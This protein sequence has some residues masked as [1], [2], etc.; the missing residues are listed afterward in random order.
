MSIIGEKDCIQKPDGTLICY[1]RDDKCYYRL[2]KAKVKPSE[3]EDDDILKLTDKLLH[4]PT[5][6]EMGVGV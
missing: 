4:N 2:T 6:S 1:D 3:L 5:M